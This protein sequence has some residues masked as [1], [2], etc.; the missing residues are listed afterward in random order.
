MK[1]KISLLP[2]TFRSSRKEIE[3]FLEQISKFK[4]K[5]EIVV[6]LEK[7]DIESF[8][9]WQELLSKDKLINY[10][11][12]SLKKLKSKGECL[13][14]AIRKSKGEYLMRCDM[15]DLILPNRYI[16]TLKII[17]KTKN[18]CDL[19]YSDM[20]D[21]ETNKLIFYPNPRNLEIASIFKN[22]IPAPTT[23]LKKDFILKNKLVLPKTNF[24]EDLYLSLFFIDNKASFYK[25]N[26]P[27]V[28]YKNNNL[29]RDYKNWFK[30]FTI[31][32]NR[33]RYDLVGLGSILFSFLLLFLGIIKFLQSTLIKLFCSKNHR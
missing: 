12:S 24:C 17:S 20:I 28:K 22:P 26:K 33:K 23:C 18:K 2:L 21:I 3:N 25:I 31:R 16:E 19:I 5:I 27:I 8:I 9:Y 6:V 30:N 14:E 7:N 4:N 29:N 10:Q 1:Y 32:L 15:D 13:N 11:L